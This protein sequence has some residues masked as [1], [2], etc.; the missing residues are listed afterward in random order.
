MKYAD[1]PLLITTT[2]LDNYA[3]FK[4]C[5]DSWKE[6]AMN[7]FIGTL[8]RK[9]WI[10]SPEIERG[11][12][13]EKRVNNLLHVEKQV[14]MDLF[15]N[16]PTPKISLFYDLCAGGIQQKKMEKKIEI[17]G[18]IFVL[19]G[20][21]DIWFPQRIIDIKTTGNFKKESYINKSQHNVYAFMEGI[22]EFIYLVAV[23][24]DEQGV[25]FDVQSIP[26]IV[27]LEMA[28]ETIRK[29]IKEVM[30]FISTDQDM[31]KAYLNTFNRF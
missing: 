5:P 8:T 11:T 9:E 1:K 4:K 25:C 14:F 16:H 29:N 7:G 17:E 20:K 2:L 22:E 31:M 15:K 27:D 28:E 18:Q 21:A 10:P 19:F 30:D 13:F 26:L 3:W 12:K 6:R 23:F 24:D